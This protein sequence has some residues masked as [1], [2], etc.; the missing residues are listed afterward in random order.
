[1][2]APTAVRAGDRQ[3]G[4]EAEPLVVGP[5]TRTHIVRYAGASGDFTPIHHDEPLAQQVGLPGVFSMGM[6][7]GGMLAHLVADWLG[8]AHV[9]RFSIRFEERVWPGDELTF[10]G[11]VVS[12]EEAA[13]HEQVTVEIACHTDSGKRALSGTAVAEY[14]A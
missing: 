9:R 13:G 8:L 12:V 3:V 1:M 11:R 14:P 4:D 2:G 7:Q 10:T 5:I 6:M